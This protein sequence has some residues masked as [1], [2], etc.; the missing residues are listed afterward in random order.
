[1]ALDTD[2]YRQQLLQ[3]RSELE[4]DIAGRTELPSSLRDDGVLD[5]AD[6]SVQEHAMDLTGRL[7][8]MKSDRLEQINAALQRIDRGD[9]GICLKCE[10]EISAKRLEAEPMALTC[11]ECQAAE[12]QNFTAPTL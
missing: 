3:E 11:I 12:E 1:M 10:K 6:H 8:N 5:S 7:M 2:K 9:Y 4:Q